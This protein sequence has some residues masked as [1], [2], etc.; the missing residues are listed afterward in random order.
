VFVGGFIPD[1]GEAG[2]DL[3]PLPGSLI[4]P[5]TLQVRPCPVESCLGRRGVVHRPAY[6]REVLAG[7]LSEHTTN[8]LAASVG[9][10]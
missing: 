6:F 9:S 10:L 8:V 3:T 1:V 5:A 4:G 2:Q 7:D